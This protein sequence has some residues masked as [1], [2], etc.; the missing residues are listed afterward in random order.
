MENSP[1]ECCP[2]LAGLKFIAGYAHFST[3]ALT[4]FLKSS[5]FSVILQNNVYL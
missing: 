3:I 1:S 5:R 2:F 4:E